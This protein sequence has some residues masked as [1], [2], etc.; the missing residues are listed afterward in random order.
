MLGDLKND[1][2]RITVFRLPETKNPPFGVNRTHRMHNP[3]LQTIDA[4]CEQAE[5]R[6]SHGRAQDVRGH[7]AE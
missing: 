5:T 6:Q 7:L 1:V 3:W 2:K 4:C